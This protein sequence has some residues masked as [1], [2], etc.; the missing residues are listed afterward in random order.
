LIEYFVVGATARSISEILN[1]NKNTVALYFHKLRYLIYENCKESIEFTGE[2]ELDE[3]YCGGSRK[4]KRGR[5]AAGKTPV[6][7]I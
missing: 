4:G 7:E 6:F 5:G 1:I 3:S 2:V